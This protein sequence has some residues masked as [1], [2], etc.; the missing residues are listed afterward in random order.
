[1]AV[2]FVSHASADDAAVRDVEAWLDA[3]GFTDRLV[4]HSG[5]V[6][7]EKWANRLSDE[8]ASCRVVLCFVSDNW[9]G[10]DECF[11]E[12]KAAW[13][14]GK[15]IVPL[16]APSPGGTTRPDRLAKVI[17]EDQ[18]LDLAPCLAPD[19]RLDLARDAEVGRRLERGLRAGGAL[20]KV[21]RP[22][23]IEF[24]WRPQLRDP[25]D[26]VAPEATRAR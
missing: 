10:S 13:Y 12:F 14:M 26:E 6:A 16:F 2:L 18:G 1:M 9:L 21:V 3:K 25:D 4:D 7:G 19:G 23:E 11:G 8:A 24:L 5:I 15:R 20:A 22:I 17:A